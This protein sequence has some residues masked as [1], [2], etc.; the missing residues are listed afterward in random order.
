M[1][2]TVLMYLQVAMYSVIYSVNVYL[3]VAMYSV[4]YS[5]NVSS[6][7]YLQCYLQC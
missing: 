1:L 7:S 3:Q 6:S 4:I 5:V 2:V